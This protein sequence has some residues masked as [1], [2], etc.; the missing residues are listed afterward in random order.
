M[1]ISETWVRPN[2]QASELEYGYMMSDP[3]QMSDHQLAS[4]LGLGWI[5]QL[6]VI[7]DESEIKLYAGKRHWATVYPA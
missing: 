7:R 6:T 4:E 1:G 5:K 3:T 2:C